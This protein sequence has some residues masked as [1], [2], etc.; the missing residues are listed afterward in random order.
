M[1]YNI[2]KC[3]EVRTRLANWVGARGGLVLCA[4]PAQVPQNVSTPKKRKTAEKFPHHQTRKTVT[5]RDTPLSEY[6]TPLPENCRRRVTTD[7]F[8][9]VTRSLYMDIYFYSP[10]FAVERGVARECGGCVCGIACVNEYVNV[11]GSGCK[12]IQSGRL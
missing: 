10:E 5:R 4:G 1:L 8:A 12:E 7:E 3:A 6:D 2:S 9:S 11:D